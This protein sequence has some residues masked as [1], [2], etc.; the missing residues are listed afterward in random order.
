[1]IKRRKPLAR[2]TPLRRIS[3]K[4]LDGDGKLKS[5]RSLPKMSKRRQRESRIYTCKRKAFLEE[6]RYCQIE[7]CCVASLSTDVHHTKGRLGG[8]YL[9][10]TTWLAAC[11]RCHDWIHTHPS[12]ARAA[13]VLK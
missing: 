1:M 11:R 6:H 10:E 2:K 5:F 13:G 12:E 9:D 8:N 4:W 7:V 3:L